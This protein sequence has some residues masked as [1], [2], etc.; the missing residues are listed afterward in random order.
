[1]KNN[2]SQLFLSFFS[3]FVHILLILHLIYPRQHLFTIFV[4]LQVNRKSPKPK[5]RV[6]PPERRLR[7]TLVNNFI[8]LLKMHTW[9][10]ALILVNVLE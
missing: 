9:I 10:K 3:Y 6:S 1:M 8:F 7:H 2:T 4:I 5:G